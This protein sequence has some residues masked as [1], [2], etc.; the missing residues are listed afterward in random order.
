MNKFLVGALA[1]SV[2]ILNLP[3]THRRN[4][5]MGMSEWPVPAPLTP[6]EALNLAAYLV[7]ATGQRAKFLELLHAIENT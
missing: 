4:E 3:I 5:A 1:D 2:V 7:A 6:D